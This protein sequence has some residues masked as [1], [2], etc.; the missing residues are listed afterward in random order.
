MKYADRDFQSTLSPSHIV[1]CQPI[2][3]EFVVGNALTE[4]ARK[5]IK[6]FS[7]AFWLLQQESGVLRFF[8]LEVVIITSILIYIRI[9][10]RHLMGKLAFDFLI[11]L[12]RDNFK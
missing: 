5:V 7:F 8:M 1:F 6:T 9:R 3:D 4:F 11:Y 10:I 2:L 12:V